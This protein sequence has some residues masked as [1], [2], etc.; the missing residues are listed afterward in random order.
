VIVLGLVAVH[1]WLPGG[2]RRF[3]EI[4]PGIFLTLVGW[5]LG[6]AIFAAYLERFSTYVTTYAGLASIMSAIV[7]LYIV[8]VI[9]IMGGELNAAIA[10][11]LAARS[12]V[13]G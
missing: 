10:R 8:S 5:I 13:I 12:R 2:T 3:V 9:F 7:F 4:V 6:S 11:F 1:F